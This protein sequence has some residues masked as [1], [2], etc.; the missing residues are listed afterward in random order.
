[1]DDFH[2]LLEKNRQSVK[3]CPCGRSNLDGKFVPFVGYT[4]KGFCHSCGKTFLPKFGRSDAKLGFPVSDYL[5]KRKQETITEVPYTLFPKE[6]FC[7]NIATCNT[8]VFFQYIKLL[9]GNF[10]ASQL[11]RKYC[12]GSN[13]YW[14]GGT[15]FWQLDIDNKVRTGKIIQYQIVKSKNALIGVECKRV[16]TNTPPVYWAHS[17]HKISGIKQCLFGEHLLG[18]RNRDGSFRVVCV[19]E[20]EKT[21]TIASVYFPNYTWLAFGGKNFDESKL[22]PLRGRTVILWPDLNCYE[23]WMQRARKLS[24]VANILVSDFLDKITNSLIEEKLSTYREDL[25]QQHFSKR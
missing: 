18:E 14:D 8:D 10:I 24:K 5:K 7:R 3:T 9:F 22:N 1:M 23:L 15:L 21:A 25:Y 17:Y 2:Y 6:I 13:D 20:S 16:K 19:V 12:I 11:V 4:D